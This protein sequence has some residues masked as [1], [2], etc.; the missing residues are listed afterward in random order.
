MAGQ[1]RRVRSTAYA[2]LRTGSGGARHGR[3]GDKPPGGI[4]GTSEG[5]PTFVEGVAADGGGWWRCLLLFLLSLFAFCSWLFLEPKFGS[6][7]LYVLL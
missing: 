4:E 2:D 7:A 3:G 5:V 1:V 6:C